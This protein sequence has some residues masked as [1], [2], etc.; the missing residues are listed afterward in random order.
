MVSQSVSTTALTLIEEAEEALRQLKALFAS[1]STP[2]EPQEYPSH[3]VLADILQRGASVTRDD[4]YE[5]ARTYGMDRRGLGG[6]FRQ[7]G[8]TSLYELAGTDKVVLTPYGAE[9]ARR[10]LER[11]PS[12]MYEEPTS[13]YAKVAEQSF[14]EDWDSEEDSVYDA[15]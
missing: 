6:L 5:L 10:V 3:L 14:A 1:D 11:R 9:T 15:L 12:I 2:Q 7:S 4:L 8:K 13:V